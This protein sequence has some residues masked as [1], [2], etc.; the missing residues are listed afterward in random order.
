MSRR[1]WPRSAG[2]TC[3]AAM[4]CST[5]MKALAVGT[6]PGPAMNA[7][8]PVAR[9]DEVAARH[10]ERHLWPAACQASGWVWVAVGYGRTTR[11]PLARR[12][13]RVLALKKSGVLLAGVTA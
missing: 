9:P 8:P 10:L 4:P 11:L 13:Q 6:G 1:N 12:S 7:C 2:V 5:W 3:G